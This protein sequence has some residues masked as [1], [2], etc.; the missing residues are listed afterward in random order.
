MIKPDKVYVT[1]DDFKNV[2]QVDLRELLN[3]NN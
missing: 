3:N 1:L 2:Y